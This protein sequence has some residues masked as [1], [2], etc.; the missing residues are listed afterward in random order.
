VRSPGAGV[1]A[2]LAVAI[3]AVSS[4]AP[5]IAYAAAPALA[6]AFW[7]NSLA[8]VVLAPVAFT[9]QRGQVKS[10]DRRTFVVCA[11]AGVA[12]A[13]HF[14]TWVPSAK[15]TSVAAATALV[16][17]MPVWS[18]LIAT[19]QGT[20]PPAVTWVG[21]AIAVVGAVLATGADFTVSRSAVLGDVL[22]LVGGLAAALYTALGDGRAPRCRPPCTRRCVTAC[23]GWCYWR[24]V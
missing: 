5:L 23:A 19:I 17:T 16:S 8:L 18:A 4:S 14:A 11:L 10:L 1:V 2:A 7:R 3:V 15:L 12:L 6:I 13:A 20:R 24:S 22:A 21:I 9:H